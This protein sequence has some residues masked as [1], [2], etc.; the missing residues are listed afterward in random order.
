[1]TKHVPCLTLMF[2]AL[3]GGNACAQPNPATILAPYIDEYTFLAGVIDVE[4]L[5]TET[6]STRLAKWDL[7]KHTLEEVR[8][9]SGKPRADLL[10]A[11]GQRLYFAWNLADNLADG[12]LW[13]VPIAQEGDAETAAIA[14]K[15]AAVLFGKLPEFST[16]VGEKVVLA[17]RKGV[18]ARQKTRKAKTVAAFASAFGEMK[19]L[20]TQVALVIPSVVRR[21]Q[22]ELLPQ[23]P[24]ELG[25]EPLT[26]LLEG[27]AFAALGLD[28]A[29]Q[30]RVQVLIQGKDDIA[31]KR[32]QRFLKQQAERIR[33][34]E[35]SE[36]AQR[37]L[38]KL[39]PLLGPDA[40]TGTQLT[41]K[42]D[43]TTFDAA[44]LTML[45]R[46]RQQ[47]ARAET[48]NNLKQIGI[49]MHVYHDIHKTFPP[50][51][52][53]SKSKKPLLS[54]RV[55]ILPYIEQQALYQ[56]FRLD[57]PWDS[58]HNKKLIAKM[59]AFYRSPLTKADVEPGKTT[60]LLPVG[61]QLLFDGGKKPTIK[62]ITDGTSNT[63][64][65]ID[66][67]DSNA[68][69]W[70]KPDDHVVNP[71][72]PRAGSMREGIGIL[73]AF[74]DGSARVLRSTISDEMLWRLFCP[75]DGKSVLIDD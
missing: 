58:E 2:L 62:Q 27:Y 29:E 20:P 48:M 74:C 15:Q 55:H 30:G 42:L 23:L 39:I 43:Q 34:E 71:R 4:N 46:A 67:P 6:L 56:E 73:C 61:P 38:Q 63:I 69:I 60:Y 51:Y 66:A 21:A 25:G 22:Q 5:D 65:V 41:W 49:A 7:S 8:Q 24:G 75:N 33:Q 45:V 36:A 40:L 18:L 13:I 11:G 14:L 12:P 19:E 68:V 47:A 9:V 52:T 26:P 57:E 44:V 16:Q 54:W 35:K 70:T 32:I 3:M 28:L 31:A 72:Q 10:K 37:I 59:P 64:M 17:G 53:I 1:M 50:Q